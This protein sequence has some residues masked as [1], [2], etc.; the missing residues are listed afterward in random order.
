M[1]HLLSMEYNIRGLA[2]HTIISGIVVNKMLYFQ[3]YPLSLTI[4]KCFLS[5]HVSTNGHL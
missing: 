5:H 3:T 4:V 1:V 2:S